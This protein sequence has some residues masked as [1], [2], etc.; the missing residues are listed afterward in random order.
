MYWTD[1]VSN[2]LQAEAEE[3]SLSKQA[4]VP[5]VETERVPA[6]SS[7][8]ETATDFWKELGRRASFIRDLYKTHRIR[9]KR[10]E[11]L[12][13][14]LD[15]AVA[16]AR[17]DK[18]MGAFSRSQLI[19]TASDAHIIYG[20][21]ESLETC[22]GAGLDISNHL[23][24]LT[25]GTADYGTPAAT[26]AKTIFLKDFEFE[27]FI[28]AAL[29]K[30]GL[31]P[32]FPK[33]RNDPR[34]EFLVSG[35]FVEAKHPNSVGQFEKMVGRFN[36]ALRKDGL[37]GVF[38][39]ALEDAYGLGDEA[40]FGSHADYERWLIAK[41]ARMETMGRQFIKHAASLSR[42]AAILQTQSKIEIVGG[43][44]TM[45]RLGNSVL[46]DHRASFCDYE[47]PAKAIAEAFNPLPVLYSTLKL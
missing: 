7:R 6:T 14:A 30:R 37:F 40:E 33:Q 17:G 12:S 32:E 29:I 11:G 5:S 13:I 41:R 42:V 18:K 22:I 31:I 26:N 35:I 45:R 34:G 21:A 9:L 8:A 23:G 44:T 43:F 38:A 47:V 1:P 25:T 39:V 3:R 2:W 20:I 46:F 16:L 36:A 24:Q 19:R 4:T 15:E 27:L 28:V 10:G